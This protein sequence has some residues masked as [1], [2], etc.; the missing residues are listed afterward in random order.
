MGGRDRDYAIRKIVTDSAVVLGAVGLLAYL[1]ALFYWIGY[2]AF[3]GIPAYF[4]NPGRSLTAWTT[5]WVWL[6]V[7]AFIVIYTLLISFLK[8]CLWKI[9]IVRKHRGDVGEFFLANYWESLRTL[10]Y[11]AYFPVIILL[12][13]V[14]VVWSGFILGKGAAEYQ[15]DFLVVSPQP[16]IGER[17]P[18]AS[19]VPPAYGPAAHAEHTQLV[20]VYSDGDLFVCAPILTETKKGGCT[21]VVLDPSALSGNAMSMTTGKPRPLICIAE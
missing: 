2:C 4:V 15:K 21:F 7:V 10:A 1:T 20:V 17:M 13:L 16:R 19:A 9:P 5:A 11:S 6:W 3:F 8:W 14:F 12:G 18:P